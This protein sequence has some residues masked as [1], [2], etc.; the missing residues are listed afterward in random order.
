MVISPESALWIPVMIL[1]RVDFPAPFSPSSAWTEP[2]FS[3][4]ETS[5]SAFTPGNDLETWATWSAVMSCLPR[6]ELCDAKFSQAVDTDGP[7]NQPAQHD[8]HDK[9]I[10]GKEHQ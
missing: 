3:V 10:D 2:G 1:M 5:S 6:I 8:L 9:G 4:I 7:E